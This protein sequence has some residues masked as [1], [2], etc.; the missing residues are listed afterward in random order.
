MTLSPRLPRRAGTGPLSIALAAASAF[1]LAGCSAAA[2][3]AA[4]PEAASAPAS[5]DAASVP[6]VPGYA[7]GDFPPIPLMEL[8]DLR[9]LTSPAAAFAAD[10]ERVVGAHPGL[11][12]APASCEDAPGGG[13]AAAPGGSL[14]VVSDGMGGGVVTTP[15]VTVTVDGQGGGTYVNE[16]NGETMA[17]DGQ[18]GGTHSHGFESLDIPG[19]GSG[20]YADGVVVIANNGDGSGSYSDGTVSIVNDGKGTALVTGTAGGSGEVPAEPLPPVP[21][22]APFPDL[23]AVQAVPSCGVAISLDNAVLFD[24][25]QAQVRADAQPVLES[26]AGAL[27]ELNP[28]SAVV[29]GHTDSVG[30]DAYNLQLSEQRAAAVVQTLQGLGTTTPLTATGYGETRPAAENTSPDGTDNPGGRQQNRRVEIFIPA[31]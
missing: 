23:A 6:V 21:D 1:G 14:E 19:D 2:P 20:A 10:V 8:P 17:I 5:A 25:D 16:T 28:A 11:R 26:L 12:V 27:G 13:S 18:G 7:P 29:S 4:D 31:A 9:L 15:T 30:D 3:Q 22:V 24:F